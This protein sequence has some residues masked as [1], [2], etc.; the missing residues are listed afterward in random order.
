MLSLLGQLNTL[1]YLPDN[2]QLKS[3]IEKALGRDTRETVKE[4]SKYPNLDY[5]E[6]VRLHDLFNSLGSDKPDRR[7][8]ERTI[9]TILKDWKNYSLMSKATAASI[10]Y[11]H[12][13]PS[14]AKQILASIRE[15]ATI[16]KTKGMWFPSLDDTW[17]NGLD[18]VGITAE[19]LMVFHNIEP[20]CADIDLLRQ[21]LILQ[22][23]AQNWGSGR[24]ATT[25]VAAILSTSG[26]WFVPAKGAKISIDGKTVKPSESEKI[27]GEL[28]TVIPAK[29]YGGKLKISRKGDTPSWGTL[30]SQYSAEMTDVKSASCPELSIEKA[31]YLS[32][33]TADSEQATSLLSAREALPLGAKVRVT[34]TVKV[35]AD[36]DYVVITDDRPACFEPVEQLPQPVY[37][38]G[39]CFYRENRDAST[40]IFIDHLP[41]G[42][43]VLSYE[44]W[45]NNAGTYTSGIATAQSEYA[46]R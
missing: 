36:M 46:P 20:D 27:T 8:V 11:K 43:Y 1:G 5:T 44:M 40:R 26:R 33:N 25:A 23:G 39:I 41:K 10:L 37:S 21:W 6:Y 15:Y 13:Y 3:M 17:L 32:G 35:N 24:I 42:T 29:E 2:R 22:K 19:I 4:F 31:L 14:V 28:K 34:L 16:D 7:I 30:F 45:A 9:Q 12:N 18:K 38:E